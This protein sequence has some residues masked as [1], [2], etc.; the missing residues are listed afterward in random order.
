[1]AYG[2]IW[3]RYVSFSLISTK[4][5]AVGKKWNGRSPKIFQTHENKLNN[6]KHYSLM[7]FIPVATATSM[8]AFLAISADVL[9]NLYT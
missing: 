9:F 4:S 7:D 1:M 6:I 3:E 8:A 5:E 2:G